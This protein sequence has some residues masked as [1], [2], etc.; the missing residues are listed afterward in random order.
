MKFIGL[1]IQNKTDILAFT[2]FLISLLSIS[3]NVKTF[4]SGARIELIEPS[5]AVLIATASPATKDAVLTAIVRYS[6]VNTGETGYS[7]LID[8]ETARFT[9]PGLEELTLTWHVFVVTTTEDA[10]ERLGGK[11]IPRIESSAA[12]FVLSG[13]GSTSHETFLA[14]QKN[15]IAVSDF[16]NA[17]EMLRKEGSFGTLPLK[18]FLSAR[19]QNHGIFRRRIHLTKTCTVQIRLQDLEALQNPEGRGYV[20]RPCLETAG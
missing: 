17:F 4:L 13:G 11:L 19:I 12:P 14:P 15:H 2:A 3:Y 10:I 20:A 1:E 6:Y 8:R 9:P 5:S 7:A 18:I 16:V